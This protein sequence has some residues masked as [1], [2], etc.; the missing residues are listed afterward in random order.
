MDNESI[1]RT[2]KIFLILSLCDRG[3]VVLCKAVFVSTP[4]LARLGYVVVELGFLCLVVHI[5]I[6]GGN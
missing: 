6:L 3:V 1:A 2:N 5:P 4:T